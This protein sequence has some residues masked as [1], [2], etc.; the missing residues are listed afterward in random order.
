MCQAIHSP[1]ILLGASIDV[2]EVDDSILTWC[3]G[4]GAVEGR[5]IWSQQICQLNGF[6]CKVHGKRSRGADNEIMWSYQHLFNENVFSLIF[7]C[8]FMAVFLLILIIFHFL[9]EWRW[10]CWRKNPKLSHRLI[11]IVACVLVLIMDLLLNT[12]EN[13]IQAW[14]CHHVGPIPWH[15]RPVSAE[16]WG[17][18]ADQRVGT[19][20]SV[21]LRTTG[22]HREM[23]VTCWSEGRYSRLCLT[24]DNRF[25]VNVSGLLCLAKS[26][27]PLTVHDDRYERSRFMMML[28][29]KVIFMMIC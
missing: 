7:H 14:H 29:V 26:M 5:C 19:A 1:L 25:P 23:R 12:D 22:F 21:S 8:C 20:N 9:S 13:S 15:G 24:E 27:A 3:C 11:L 18:R 4:G 28:M 16:R 17:L 2:S 6:V 10:Y